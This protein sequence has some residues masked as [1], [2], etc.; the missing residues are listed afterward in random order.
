MPSRN[1]GSKDK[2]G[3]GDGSNWLVTYADMMTLLLAFFVLLFSFSTI[4]EHQFEA[5]MDALRGRLGILEGG[6]TISDAELITAGVMDQE[7]GMHDLYNIEQSISQYVAEEG[8]E[9]QV[10]VEMTDRGLM[11]RFTGK[12]LFDL[13]RAEIRE[14]AFPVLGELAELVAEIPN[15]IMVEGH[16]DNLPISTERFPSN[17]ELSTARATNVVRYFI[18]EQGLEATKLSA[19]G[20]SE[21]RPIAPND[22]AENRA[23]NRRVDVIVLREQVEEGMIDEE[24]LGEDELDEYQLDEDELEQLEADLLEEG[25]LEEDA[26]E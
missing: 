13:G 26:L 25:Q 12:V 1:K 8:L 2:G 3:G 24:I 16:T 19:A 20:Y 22:T 21:Y 7:V 9:D 5:V 17:W 6:K 15:Q 14:E 10:D 11:I 4:D 23:Q 18:E